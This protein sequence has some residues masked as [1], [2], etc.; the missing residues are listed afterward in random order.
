MTASHRCGG[1]LRDLPRRGASS[2]RPPPTL[3]AHLT[4]Y[5]VIGLYLPCWRCTSC[6]HS[7]T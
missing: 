5:R 4:V 7:S 2:A 6:P 1:V 3:F